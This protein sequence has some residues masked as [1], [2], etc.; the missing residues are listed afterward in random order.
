M[1]NIG[2]RIK[3]N[4]FSSLFST[5]RFHVDGISFSESYSIRLSN[6]HKNLPYVSHCISSLCKNLPIL[7]FFTGLYFIKTIQSQ[8]ICKISGLS[9]IDKIYLSHTN[10]DIHLLIEHNKG[11]SFTQL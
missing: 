10:N 1:K 9:E 3:Q 5:M 7:L 2:N 6:I 4:Y 8:E 11:W